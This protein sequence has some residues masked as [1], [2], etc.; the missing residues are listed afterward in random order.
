MKVAKAKL[1][2]ASLLAVLLVSCFPLIVNAEVDWLSGYNR[3]MLFYWQSSGAGQGNFTV[4][5][6][7]GFNSNGVFYIFNET[8][9]D[10]E[11][12]NVTLADGVTPLA[13][14]NQTTISGVRCNVWANFPT[15]NDSYFLYWNNLNALAG[16]NQTGVFNAVL[17]DVGLALPMDEGSGNPQDVSGHG[18]NG[19]LNGASWVNTGR[20]GNALSFNGLSNSVN[21]SDVTGSSIDFT[22]KF[23][24]SCWMKP[25]G[26][27]GNGLGRVLDKAVYAVYVNSGSPALR[28][29]GGVVGVSSNPSFVLNSNVFVT[30]TYDSSLPFNNLKFYFN[31][32]LKNSVNTT[33]SFSVNNNVLFIGNRADLL[34]GFN[35]TLSNVFLFNGSLSA[36]QVGALAAGYGDGRLES[37]KVLVRNYLVG[38]S[39]SLFG[40]VESAPVVEPTVDPDVL[41]G[42][43]AV[44]VAVAFGVIILGVCVGLIFSQ[45]RKED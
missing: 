4:V 29:D 26:Y 43:D 30:V 5:N 36:V 22:N 23:T 32:T 13:L 1:L 16:W 24:F 12:L 14:W 7:T 15:A 6:A 10:F 8:Q 28:V 3:R 27:G 34:R 45:R 38:A 39:V 41:T 37:G 17:G 2:S 19:V 25:I 44:G 35:G 40:S 20:F 33:T 9:P 11:D 18:L 21:V 31:G 42:E